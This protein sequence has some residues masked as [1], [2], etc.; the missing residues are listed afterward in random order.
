L[1]ETKQNGTKQNTTGLEW[2][3][4]GGDLVYLP[5]GSSDLYLSK[6]F[7]WFLL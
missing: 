4:D 6:I 1:P 5:Q 2:S 7:S 3:R